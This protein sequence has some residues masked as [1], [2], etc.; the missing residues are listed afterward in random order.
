MNPYQSE[1][2]GRQAGNVRQR[3][4]GMMD[5]NACRYTS[6]EFNEVTQT[7]TH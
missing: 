7:D 4:G 5:L 3:E 2:E 1:K 6:N